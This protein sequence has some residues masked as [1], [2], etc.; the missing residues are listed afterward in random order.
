MT[1]TE[2]LPIHSDP[3]KS[4]SPSFK[5]A[6]NYIGEFVYQG[7]ALRQRRTLDFGKME[8]SL[9]VIA[10][11]LEDG[12]NFH[13]AAISL[14]MAAKLSP[15]TWEEQEEITEKNRVG[16]SALK[17]I[18]D[19]SETLTKRIQVNKGPSYWASMLT[20]ELFTRKVWL[21]DSTIRDKALHVLQ[22]S[23][24]AVKRVIF[25]G[26]RS[27]GIL[28]KHYHTYLPE[29][30][31]SWLD[32]LSRKLVFHPN[33]ELTS[34]MGTMST[35]DTFMDT[36]K[37]IEN[38][39]QSRASKTSFGFLKNEATEI[40]NAWVASTKFEEIGGRIEENL[41][42]MYELEKLEPGSVKYLNSRFGIN[43]FGRY[44]VN[45]LIAQYQ[46]KNDKQSPYG[47]ILYPYGDH[48]GAFYGDKEP[49]SNFY[50]QLC[51]IT[52]NNGAKYRV[53]VFECRNLFSLG[54]SVV[55][56]Y[57][58]YGKIHFALIGGHGSRERIWFGNSETLSKDDLI[59]GKGIQRA[60]D[61]FIPQPPIVL[62]ACSAGKEGGIA[63]EMSKLGGGEVH[64]ASENTSL[65]QLS[66]K[67]NNDLLEISP[68]YT[69]G[70]TATYRN[71]KV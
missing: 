4:F 1:D 18:S 13:E 43:C 65:D 34:A 40:V 2:P 64:G 66:V 11:G 70:Q 47:L 63:E 25:S 19:H 42:S 59:Q 45:M 9:E 20:A 46:S 48:N 54:R 52:R 21:I 23:K 16:L 6:Q 71:G 10:D 39:L 15:Y 58:E 7:K 36:R 49:F 57:H 31:K 32:E 14:Y 22:D 5:E 17:L 30:Y 24:D 61:F 28:I 68:K 56:S 51:Q 41:K 50:K 44:P 12:R 38:I 53:R 29:V 55:S 27:G 3:E 8:K 35:P 33:P 60:V 37:V 62:V 26:S 69:K 67:L